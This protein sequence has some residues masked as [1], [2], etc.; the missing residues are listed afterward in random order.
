[1]RAPRLRALAVT[2]TALAGL[3]P[4]PA[5]RATH[6]QIVLTFTGP[7]I[8]RM[9]LY[10][11]YDDA[12]RGQCTIVVMAEAGADTSP[13]ATQS[14]SCDFMMWGETGSTLGPYGHI[15]V[16][17]DLADFSGTYHRAGYGTAFTMSG[18]DRSYPHAGRLVGAGTIVT[19]AAPNEPGTFVVSGVLQTVYSN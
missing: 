2:V 7:A 3:L 15:D 19:T 13:Y 16:W 6:R 1:M 10:P 17:S 8:G 5:A 4:A 18:I 9:S 14:L 12:F 11:R